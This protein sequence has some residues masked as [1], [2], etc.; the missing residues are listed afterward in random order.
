MDTVRENAAQAAVA[1][2]QFLARNALAFGQGTFGFL[3]QFGLMLYVAYFLLR[4]G[5][6]LVDKL[7]RAVLL[8]DTRERPL[9]QKFAE[10]A[11]AT[12]KGSLLVWLAASAR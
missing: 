7:I 12:V 2:S 5:S 6:V 11:R 3:L 8:G 4:D 10:V 9:F 1:T